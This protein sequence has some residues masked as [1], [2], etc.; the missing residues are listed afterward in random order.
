[1]SEY[2]HRPRRTAAGGLRPL[3][4]AWAR[5]AFAPERPDDHV[6]A[7]IES[8]AAVWPYGSRIE[9]PL[10]VVAAAVLLPLAD[11]QAESLAQRIAALEPGELLVVLRGTWA[12][13]WGRQPY[14]VERA[15]P[16]FR[17]L[18]SV[19]EETGIAVARVV[20]VALRAGVLEHGADPD[21]FLAADLLG[22]LQQR[23]TG[24]GEKSERG[25]F[26]TP[27][28][29]ADHMAE[30][31][32][33]SLVEGQLIGETAA[34]SGTML[35]AVARHL[36]RRGVDPA[37]MRWQAVELSELSAAT[38][39][40]N[41]ML[42]RLGDRVVIACSDALAGD[43]GIGQAEAERDGCL[44]HRDAAVAY[45]GERDGGT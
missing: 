13:L 17:W 23:M 35:R 25:A 21:R 10:G 22:R 43:S 38:L 9:I 42:W 18:A 15:H 40:C 31:L 14:L 8:V 3:P 16:L 7:I 30:G 4:P 37:A 28:M 26:H 44:A 6:K 1:V 33:G 36:R 32:A 5:R 39:A 34:G 19:S 27:D 41:A 20:Q 29:A 11:P 12:A 45:L 2:D 24:R